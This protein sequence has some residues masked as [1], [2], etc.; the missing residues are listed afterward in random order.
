MPLLGRN[1]GSAD[2]LHYELWVM[3][4]MQGDDGMCMKE[5]AINIVVILPLSDTTVIQCD[6]NGTL[7]VC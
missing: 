7:A 5:N 3:I 2:K 1:M 6:H 4:V